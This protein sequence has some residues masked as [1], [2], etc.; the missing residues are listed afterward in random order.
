MALDLVYWS[1]Y[2]AYNVY[3]RLIAVLA[4]DDLLAG[5]SL[6][7]NPATPPLVTSWH[8]TA[9]Q[10]TPTSSSNKTSSQEAGDRSAA[11]TNAHS[12]I[13]VA[14]RLWQDSVRLAQ[15]AMTLLRMILNNSSL[16][17]ALILFHEHGHERVI[18][19][20]LQRERP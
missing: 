3:N 11:D 9:T 18:H 7:C 16:G 15:E 6:P 2:I 13:E 17:R 19:S 20:P 10:Q 4:A 5:F 14:A 8:Q 12:S 1:L